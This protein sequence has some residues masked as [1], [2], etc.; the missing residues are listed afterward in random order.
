MAYGGSLLAF[1]GCSLVY[2]GMEGDLYGSWI[3]L[4]GS[5]T[6]WLTIG[7]SIVCCVLPPLVLQG[8]QENFLEY[9]SN[10]VHILKRT[11]LRM[12]SGRST[13]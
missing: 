3:R 9:K 5:A 4:L 12:W 10:P 7:L 6:F 13:R 1:V 11:K 8:Y 2:D